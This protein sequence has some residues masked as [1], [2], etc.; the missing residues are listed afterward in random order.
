LLDEFCCKP[1]GF[2]RRY[3]GSTAPRFVKGDYTYKYFEVYTS[4]NKQEVFRFT[5]TKET[6]PKAIVWVE[7]DN[8]E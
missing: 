6:S 8:K 3:S 7:L 2:T 5:Y 4:D 1:P